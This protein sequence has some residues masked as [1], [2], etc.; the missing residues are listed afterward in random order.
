LMYKLP[1]ES[2]PAKY[3]LTREIVEAK[4]S[5]FAKEDKMKK[6]SA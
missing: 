3:V 1:E 2:K 5:P 4:A 6:E